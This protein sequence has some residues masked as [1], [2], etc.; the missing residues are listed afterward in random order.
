MR[1]REHLYIA[2][3]LDHFHGGNC[4]A[5]GG[6]DGS[7]APQCLRVISRRKVFFAHIR[8]TMFC[9]MRGFLF[10]FAT[11]SSPSCSRPIPNVCGG[12]PQLFPKL[13]TGRQVELAD[14]FA[15]RAP[16]PLSSVFVGAP[17]ITSRRSQGEGGCAARGAGAPSH[18]SGGISGIHVA[19][20]DA[21]KPL[22]DPPKPHR[23]AHFVRT[24]VYREA[25]DSHSISQSSSALG[26]R[27]PDSWWS[28]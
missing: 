16:A 25:R 9:L 20:L 22:G 6:V 23:H 17:E 1:T 8:W 15:L 21:P 2:A 19:G 24:A 27:R 14:Y 3:Q 12:S 18:F 7:H 26:R 11:Q 5:L 4:T 28:L 13:S 10:P